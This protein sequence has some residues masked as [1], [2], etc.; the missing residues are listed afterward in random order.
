[1]PTRIRIKHAAGTLGRRRLIEF[2]RRLSSDT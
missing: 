2:A 1:M